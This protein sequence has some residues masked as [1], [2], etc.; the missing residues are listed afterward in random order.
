M[1]LVKNYEKWGR[2]ARVNYKDKNGYQSVRSFTYMYF[3][4]G[5]QS[6]K[7]NSA[8][9]GFLSADKDYVATYVDQYN[10]LV[11]ETDPNGFGANVQWEI[12]DYRQNENVLYYAHVTASYATLAGG[13]TAAIEK[14]SWIDAYAINQPTNA[15]CEGFQIS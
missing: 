1:Y 13:T 6:G 15:K 10:R 2:K 9:V 7:L 3:N 14:N 4:S 11:L 5:T 12:E 8:G